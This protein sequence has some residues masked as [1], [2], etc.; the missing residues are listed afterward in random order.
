MVA[1]GG[2][3]NREHWTRPC[4]WLLVVTFYISPKESKRFGLHD[5]LWAVLQIHDST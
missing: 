2:S 1:V 5:C 3:Y 4:Q